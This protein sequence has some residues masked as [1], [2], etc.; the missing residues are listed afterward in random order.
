MSII[1]DR[2]LRKAFTLIE[3]LVVIAIIALLLAIITPSLSKAKDAA[4]LM[5]CG[6]NQRQCLEGVLA[7]SIDHDGLL[8]AHPAERDNGTFSWVNYLNYHQSPHKDSTNARNHGTYYYLGSYLPTIEVF[9]CPLGPK[10][11]NDLQEQY[12]DYN[13]VP[14]GT[15]VS[16]NMYWGGYELNNIRF[17]G[18]RG[19]GDRKN[20]AN[21]LL[22]DSMSYWM[23]DQWWLSH[24]PRQGEVLTQLTDP[25]F[26]NDCS[27]FWIWQS[28]SDRRPEDLK[29]N[30]GYTDGS[31][32]RYT[33]QETI[34][35]G[36]GHFWIPRM[37]R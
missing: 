32:R 3:L 10:W 31:V 20:A 5:I 18:P 25:R 33:A 12:V 6:A 11:A 27:I 17:K 9:M 30:A 29:M 37:W 34:L 26:G 8:P 21:L 15:H 16:Y 7:Y 24:R 36:S 28:P 2:N 13:H 19:K 14:E 23:D 1:M 4:R 22:S 35:G